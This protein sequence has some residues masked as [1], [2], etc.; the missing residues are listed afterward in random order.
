MI[1]VDYFLSIHDSPTRKH[2]VWGFSHADKQS[3]RTFDSDP[4]T[5]NVLMPTTGSP[6]SILHRK[7]TIL[8]ECSASASRNF[9]GS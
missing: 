4:S 9:S 2:D 3:L 6:V 7:C 1:S 8:R 5:R